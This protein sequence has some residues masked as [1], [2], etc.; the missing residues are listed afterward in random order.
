MAKRRPLAVPHRAPARLLRHRRTR[1]AALGGFD[2]PRGGR[3]EAGSWVRRHWRSCSSQ[4]PPNPPTPP[5]L[6]F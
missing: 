6:G 3:R 5:T 1:L 4:P 2:T